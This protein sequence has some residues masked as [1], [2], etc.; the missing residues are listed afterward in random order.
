MGVS[1]KT[2][3]TES[4]STKTMAT[5]AVSTKLLATE[6]I[7]TKAVSTKTMATESM[8][9]KTMTTMTTETMSTKTLLTKT[10][11]KF[12]SPAAMD[13]FLKKEIKGSVQLHITSHRCKREERALKNTLEEYA[14]KYK[15]EESRREFEKMH[16][17]QILR[18]FN[19]Q[20]AGMVDR[21]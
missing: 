16:L 10:M 12:D 20:N 15:R 14:I 13:C 19:R 3:A 21:S 17:Q 18:T 6:A 7:S 5:K 9:T 11:S 2:M 4:M 8:S 1:T